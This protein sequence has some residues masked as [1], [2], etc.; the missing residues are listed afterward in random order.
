[1]D[2]LYFCLFVIG[3]NFIWYHLSLSWHLC[4]LFV[5]SCWCFQDF[6]RHFRDS[7][8]ELGGWVS[9]AQCCHTGHLYRENNV[10]VIWVKSSQLFFMFCLYTEQRNM[11]NDVISHITSKVPLLSK[12]SVFKQFQLSAA[13]YVLSAQNICIHALWAR[14]GICCPTVWVTKSNSAVV[15]FSF[16]SLLLQSALCPEE[17]LSSNL[18]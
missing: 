1:M 11:G 16:C 2:C 14:S 7:W 5:W 4:E 8:C 3:G 13:H 17:W 15:A 9:D 6:Q 12:P 18:I 10:M